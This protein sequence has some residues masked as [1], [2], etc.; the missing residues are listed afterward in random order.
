MIPLISVIVPTFNS[1]KTLKNTLSSIK[2]QSFIDYEVIL[3]DAFSVDDTVQIIKNY[4]EFRCYSL[5]PAGVYSAINF[6]I[7][8]ALGE[9]LYVMGSDDFLTSDKE[10]SIVASII[11]INSGLIGAADVIANCPP[12]LH[13]SYLGLKTLLINTLHHQGCFYHKSLFTNFRFSTEL[14]AIADYELTLRCFILKARI[15]RIPSILAICSPYGIS[16]S[17]SPEKII[18]E[19]NKA[20]W[21]ALQHTKLRYFLPFISLLTRL[22]VYRY[23]L[24]TSVF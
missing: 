6:G 24:T 19:F 2:M 1:G 5:E 21:N 16:N 15:I 4:P 11:T 9:W 3:V 20:R 23:K 10:F 13:R 12:R 8:V 14:S 18:F 22:N 17:L 7:D